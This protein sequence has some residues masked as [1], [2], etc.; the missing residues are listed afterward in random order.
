MTQDSAARPV[1]FV[2]VINSFNR[3]A[4]LERALTSLTETLRSAPFGSA[5]IVFEAGSNDGSVEFLRTWRDNN[6]A[7]NL[8]IIE[9]P[10]GRSSFSDGVNT[11]CAAAISRFA[12][13]H[14]LFLYE[15]DNCLTSVEPLQ[16]AIALLK[17]EPQLAAVGF[18]VKQH[19]GKFYG[20][21]MRFP[22]ALSFALGQNLAAR[23]NLHAPNNSAWQ[24][25]D[26]IRWRTCD[27]VFT[28]PLLIR[29]NKAAALTRKIFHFRTATLI[30]R[31]AARSSAGKWRLFRR[32]ASFMIIS[33]SCQPGPRTALS[34]FIAIVFAF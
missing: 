31:G 27:V 18:T 10:T 9:A 32:T 12:K 5:I 19:D 11:G 30:G 3:R 13:C 21:G 25:R 16:K 7:D 17:I 1:E 15:T 34:I 28:S 23:L 6:P 20:Y 22:S 33:N 4:L 26:G 8:S 2:A 29:R 14:W 24:T